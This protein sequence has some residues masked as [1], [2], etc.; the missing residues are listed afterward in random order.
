MQEVTSW[1]CSEMCR[2][3]EGMR[4]WERKKERVTF[5]GEK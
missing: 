2:D 3:G 5:R 1:R 4:E